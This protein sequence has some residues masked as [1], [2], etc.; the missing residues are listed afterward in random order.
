MISPKSISLSA[1]VDIGV[2][3]D[4]ILAAAAYIDPDSNPGGEI[5]GEPDWELAGNTYDIDSAGITQ[6][7]SRGIVQES[8]LE[9]YVDGVLV[10]ASE[11]IGPITVDRSRDRAIQTWSFG[12]CVSPETGMG[13]FGN[14]IGQLGTPLGKRKVSIYAAYRTNAGQVY[15]YPLLV[16]GICHSYSGPSTRATHLETHSGVDEMGCLSRSLVD[17]VKAQGQRIPRHEAIRAMFTQAGATLFALE[18]MRRTN[19]PLQYVEADPVAASQELCEVEGRQIQKGPRGEIRNPLLR[20]KGA[21]QWIIR[22]S[23]L[24]SFE[25]IAPGDV[26]TRVVVNGTEYVAGE[27]EEGCPAI[28]TELRR[29]TDTIYRPKRIRWQQASNCTITD[30]G[31]PT[32]DPALIQTR[33]VIHK[34][35]TRCGVLVAE[36]IEVWEWHAR[37][38]K[39]YER[40]TPT[41]LGCVFQAKF[42]ESDD[43]PTENG[44]EPAVAEPERWRLVQRTETSHYYDLP[45]WQYTSGIVALSP[46]NP[47]YCP[48]LQGDIDIDL[49]DQVAPEPSVDKYR[50]NTG[51]S[52]YFGSYLGSITREYGYYAPRSAIKENQN[53]SL[54]WDEE[55]YLIGVYVLGSGDAATGLPTFRLLRAETREVHSNFNREIVREVVQ[56]GSFLARGGNTYLYGDGTTRR[57]L[58]EVIRRTTQDETLYTETGEST[59]QVVISHT[60]LSESRFNSVVSEDRDGALPQVDI[61]P[62]MDEEV[63]TEVQEGDGRS[64]PVASIKAAMARHSTNDENRAFSTPV[65][66]TNLESRHCVNKSVISLPMA[67][68]EQEAEE[69]GKMAIGESSALVVSL[70]VPLN[71]VMDETDAATLT[72][73]PRGIVGRRMEFRSLNHQLTDRRTF[74]TTRISGRIYLNV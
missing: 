50:A 29:S 17:Y 34:R 54:T 3:S 49:G 58:S 36:V 33:L 26:I 31:A 6:A 38:A 68:N 47:I 9:V 4:T 16:D 28:T 65:T 37:E 53:P 44:S 10:P 11:I 71:G 24:L 1:T 42:L 66:S 45:G 19:K 2:H 13:P 18:P 61:L 46:F 60:N 63:L 40:D 8:T 67:E 7:L 15:R 22:E 14:P 69:Y 57:E 41:T 25:L 64:I 23:D 59:H 73:R 43:V 55:D 12:T 39:R 30:L 32:H 27:G 52:S 35:V 21:A 20:G 62:F 72:F 51:E 70:E 5:V 74:P 56:A 48:R